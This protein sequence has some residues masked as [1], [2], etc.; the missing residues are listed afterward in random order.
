MLEKTNS[1][2]SNRQR[3]RHRR[4]NSGGSMTFKYCGLLIRCRIPRCCSV[5]SIVVIGNPI[6]TLFTHTHTPGKQ[7]QIRNKP[8]LL[9]FQLLSLGFLRKE[10]ASANM[11]R[12]VA[13]ACSF[14]IKIRRKLRLCAGL[15]AK[16]SFLP[17]ATPALVWH[18]IP[19][20]NLYFCFFF[21]ARGTDQP[22][23]SRCV[24][25]VNRAFS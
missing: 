19:V 3:L 16:S 6:T 23:C 9:A 15:C 1:T 8:G 5:G 24:Q 11:W 4:S 17:C 25:T 13:S 10:S 21:L 7:T 20:M 12:I 22:Q 14:S 18:G 2:H